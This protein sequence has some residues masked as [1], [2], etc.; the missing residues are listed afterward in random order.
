M[1]Q[2]KKEFPIGSFVR[3]QRR[4]RP[5]TKF[6]QEPFWSHK[7]YSIVNYKRPLSQV[8]PVAYYLSDGTKTLPGIYYSSEI[9]S[10]I[11]N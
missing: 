7:L 3:I 11:K 8:E 2:A 6:S 9:K 1:N 4:R 10:V 5:F